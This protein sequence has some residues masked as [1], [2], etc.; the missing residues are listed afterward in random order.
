M[1]FISC[2]GTGCLLRLIYLQTVKTRRQNL[3]KGV[4]VEPD[5][6]KQVPA[7]NA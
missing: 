2:N 5:V 1:V 3:E 7:M 4:R 6:W